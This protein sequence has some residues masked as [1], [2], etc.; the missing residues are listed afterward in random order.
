M[1]RFI[2][3]TG[4]ALASLLA[5][6]GSL[7]AQ[8]NQLTPEEKS[9]GWILLFNGTDLNGWH[10]YN[11]KTASAPWTVED[12]AIK[13]DVPKKGD[14]DGDLVSTDEYENFDFKLQWKISPEGNSGI[15]FL[16]KEKP[17]LEAYTTGPEMQVLDNDGHPDGKIPKHRAGDLYDL[18]SSSSEPVR[19][20]GQWNDAEIKLDHGK[21]DLYL[22]GVNVVS[23]T[24]GD[25]NWN[26]LVKGSKF[27]NMPYFAKSKSGH[28]DLQN[29]GNPVWYRNIKIKKL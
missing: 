8:E 25:A 20:V 5:L 12:G 23:T 22:N 9:S 13:K 16:I 24:I 11:H 2:K 19:P 29:H 14:T 10:N 21:L 15:L 18:I 7:R 28:V 27:A 17:G 6:G 3:N 1:M 4:L 26:K